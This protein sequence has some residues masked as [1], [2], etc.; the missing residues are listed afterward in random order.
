MNYNKD[1]LDQLASM[2]GTVKQELIIKIKNH[3]WYNFV[4]AR[5]LKGKQPWTDIEMDIFFSENMNRLYEIVENI[6]TEHELDSLESN[7]D[8]E[9]YI[10]EVLN[11]LENID[12]ELDNVNNEI[13]YQ[14]DYLK[15]NFVLQKDRKI[16]EYNWSEQKRQI[17][18]F[19]N[20]VYDTNNLV[21]EE[22][23]KI[24]HKKAF[25]IPNR[26]E[27]VNEWLEDRIPGF[28]QL[29]L[30]RFTQE[31]IERF[32][33]S[34]FIYHFNI[35]DVRD[36]LINFICRKWIFNLE[37]IKILKDGWKE[38][39]VDDSSIQDKV[40]NFICNKHQ[41]ILRTI[42]INRQ[43]NSFTGEIEDEYFLIETENMNLDI[44]GDGED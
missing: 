18:L 5:I 30:A 20:E 10:N 32:P 28:P 23:L 7:I 33:N 36:G 3:L 9:E 6:Y 34:I 27:L 38:I 26:R 35:L 13:D 39:P 8:I 42:N 12:I 43:L 31:L 11:P 2:I 15:N 44:I 14:N 17:M 41:S 1:I 37:V 29:Y 22:R 4:T 16:E 21:D 24:L 40:W 19:I 25:M